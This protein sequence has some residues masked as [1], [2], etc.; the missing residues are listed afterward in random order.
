M[1]EMGCDNRIQICL[2]TQS[3]QLCGHSL[4]YHR[5]CSMDRR[6]VSHIVLSTKIFFFVLSHH[7]IIFIERKPERFR[8]V[9]I[10]ICGE[11]ACEILLQEGCVSS[12]CARWKW[13]PNENTRQSIDVINFYRS[14]RI[15]KCLLFSF[16]V[17]DDQDA[18]SLNSQHVTNIL[19]KSDFN[20]FNGFLFLHIFA[21]LSVHQY[22]ITKRASISQP[23]NDSNVLIFQKYL[24]ICLRRLKLFQKNSVVWLVVSVSTAEEKN[25]NEI[26][27]S[28]I[29]RIRTSER[30]KNIQH[31]HTPAIAFSEVRNEKQF[32]Q[33]IAFIYVFFQ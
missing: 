20:I 7:W 31:G 19:R 3:A 1:N 18:I 28:K 5:M 23:T 25:E 27:N 26:L 33:R 21:R 15:S 12:G 8:Y 2:T 32:S 9:L 11:F 22:I 30:C 14:K 16:V 6:T 13:R 29:D 17:S 10:L 24:L 4:V